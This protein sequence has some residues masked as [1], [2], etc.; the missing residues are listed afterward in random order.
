MKDKLIFML[1]ALSIATGCNREADKDAK[2]RI[3]V[4]INVTPLAAMSLTETD[5]KAPV[6]EWSNTSVNMALG[7]TQG[8]SPS[9]Y[10]VV[11]S[12]IVH[13]NV[14]SFSP[15]LFYPTNG[16]Y[17]HLRGYHPRPV[18]TTITDNK[19]KYTITGQEDIMVSN[20]VSGS[21]SNPIAGQGEAGVV[22][23]EHLLTQLNF[24]LKNDGTFPS[25]VKVTVIRIKNLSLRATLDLTDGTLTFD[26]PSTDILTAYSNPAGLEVLTTSS[27][28]LG[29][30][31]IQP[32]AFGA[33]ESTA[34]EI[35]FS[36]GDKVTVSGLITEESGH[37]GEVVGS[38]AGSAYMV[39]LTFKGMEVTSSMV[40]VTWNKKDVAETP[41]IPINL[42]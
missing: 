3:S 8:M 35:E 10:T 5:T 42:W 18:A 24:I 32:G 40:P 33:G 34:I 1:I 17:I 6:T 36:T 9:N 13:N 12:A 19:V 7:Q 38:K 11:L 30:I 41:K 28:P 37:E 23:Y 16:E 14:T 25:S 27:A 22:T 15:K 20:V 26:S 21:A 31:M 4:V 2:D 39:V 29:H